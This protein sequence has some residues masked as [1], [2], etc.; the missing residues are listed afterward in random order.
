MKGH[1][2][3][4]FSKLRETSWRREL[5]SA[6]ESALRDWLAEHPEAREDW[7]ADAA[8]N[9][10]LE[11]LP[12]APVPSNFTARVIQAVELEKAVALREPESRWKWVWR[13]FVPKVAL[14]AV[15][16]GMRR[17]VF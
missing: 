7:E 5:T 13:S 3:D 9:R 12:E 16:V 8:L 1:M 4:P 17:R 14:A 6:E 11:R 15:F 2:N 10:V